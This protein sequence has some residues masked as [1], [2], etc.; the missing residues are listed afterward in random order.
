[1][2]IKLVED[3][4]SPVYFIEGC[5]KEVDIP[6]DKLIWMQRTYAEFQKVQDY[7]QEIYKA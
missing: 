6:E 5:G 2:I 3:E 4:W 7:L 1:M